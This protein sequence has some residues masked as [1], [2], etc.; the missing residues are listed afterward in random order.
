VCDISKLASPAELR[1]ELAL[2]V[3]RAKLDEPEP[4]SGSKLL[5]RACIKS[6]EPSRALAKLGSNRLMAI[7]AWA[8]GTP[9]S[10]QGSGQQLQLRAVKKKKVF[11]RTMYSKVNSAHTQIN[12]I[13]SLE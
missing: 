11:Q 9:H 5:S 10:S 3:I 2:S 13:H 12:T 6:V 7:S 1:A 8:V 4:S